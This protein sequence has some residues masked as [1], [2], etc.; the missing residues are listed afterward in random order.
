MAL[1]GQGRRRRAAAAAA[2]CCKEKTKGKLVAGV[3]EAV[4]S[5]LW[6]AC[7]MGYSALGLT[8]SV[9]RLSGMA[10]AT[11]LPKSAIGAPFSPSSAAGNAISTG[12]Y[13]RVCPSAAGGGRRRHAVHGEQVAMAPCMYVHLCR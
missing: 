4:C 8:C 6:W 13:A 5:I 9:F 7:S 2:A 11:S 1:A 3:D 10:T 12:C